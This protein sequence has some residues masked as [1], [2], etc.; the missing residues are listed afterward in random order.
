MYPGGYWW[1]NLPVTFEQLVSEPGKAIRYLATNDLLSGCE[2]VTV[3]R[4]VEFCTRRGLNVDASRL[5]RLERLRLF[6]PLLRVR[7]PK[8]QIKV[9]RVDE[10]HIK[11]LGMLKEGEQWEGEL[12][13]E[14]SRLSWRPDWI[15]Q[16][17]ENDLAWDPRS[18]RFTNWSAFAPNRQSPNVES[19]YS[20]FQCYSL[21]NLLSALTGTVSLEQLVD[22]PDSSQKVIEAFAEAGRISA[23]SLRVHRRG[24]DAALLA[25]IL[26]ARY[27]FYTQGDQ[28]TMNVPSPDVDGWDWWLFSQGWRAKEVAEAVGASPDLVKTMHG[29]VRFIAS[30]GDPLRDWYELVSFVSLNKKAK[31]KGDAQF[32]QFGYD[33]EHMLRL[34]YLDLTGI[35]LPLPDEGRGWNRN[36]KYGGGEADSP[37]R[38]LEFLVNEYNLNPRPKALLIVEGEGEATQLPR[39]ALGLFGVDFAV[40]GIE[41]RALRGIDEFEGR[42]SVDV[43]GALEKL[44]DDYHARQTIVYI[45]LDNESRAEHARERLLSARSRLVPG[46]R[47]TRHEYI[48]MW[49]A[50]FEFD[51][52]TDAEIATAISSTAEGRYQ[53][54]PDEIAECRS[55]WNNEPQKKDYLSVLYADRLNYKLRKTV[56]MS[57]LVDHVIANSQTELPESGE[58]YRP[59]VR[60]IKTLIELAALN[61]QP[62]SRESWLINQKTGY[63]G[64]FEEAKDSSGP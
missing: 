62:E 7:Y 59:I 60:V 26:S 36:L 27:Y 53:F 28:R 24:E 45:V 55:R 1:Q 33:M 31:L 9:E 19:F 17:I 5:E 34:F 57:L 47:L 14:N 41:V 30:I 25:Q 22:A 8:I 12:R 4:F 29:D 61:H 56:L 35:K 39:L 52:F 18:R 46:R 15:G 32:A 38:H 51:N 54:R 50:T 20:I 42:R 40:A 11:T 23:E 37:L 49:S 44:I 16:W 48:K 6:F 43:Y 21:S 63:F 64:L 10:A 3:S 2:P 58:P 13:E